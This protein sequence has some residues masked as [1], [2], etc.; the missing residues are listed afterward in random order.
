MAAT[1]PPFAAFEWLIAWRYLRA[2]YG[3]DEAEFAAAH[4]D[5]ARERARMDRWV[6]GFLQKACAR[7]CA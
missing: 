7:P 4:G 6:D 2:R 5:A 1:P 3:V